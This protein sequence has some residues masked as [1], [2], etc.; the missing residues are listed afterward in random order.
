MT[1]KKGV[2][3]GYEVYTQPIV[4]PIVTSPPSLT[5][6]PGASKTFQISESAYTGPFTV[7]TCKS[8]A[9]TV[10]NVAATGAHG[11]TATVTVTGVGAGGSCTIAISDSYGQ[12]ASEN[13]TVNQPA[14][15]VTPSTLTLTGNAPGSFTGSAQTA[16]PERS[17]SGPARRARRPSRPPHQHGERA[18]GEHHGDAGEGRECT[19][20]VSDTNGQTTNVSVTVNTSALTIGPTALQFATAPSA[21]DPVR[22]GQRATGYS[23]SFTYTPCKQG[24]TTV[25]MLT[26][27]RSPAPAR[28]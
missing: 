15:T 8:G 6:A 25:A 11:P 18:V 19:I 5:V 20:A 24:A 12:T 9:T 21:P 14:L 10:A 1:F 7:G 27:P 26:R 22:H 23:G 13:V 4:D 2:L 3:Y 28:R 16:T 17:A